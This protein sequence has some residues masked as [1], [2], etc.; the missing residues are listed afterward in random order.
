MSIVVE[1]VNSK[2]QSICFHEGGKEGEREE[3]G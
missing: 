2:W 3:G 1:W